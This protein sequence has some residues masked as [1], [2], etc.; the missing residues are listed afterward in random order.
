M[1]RWMLA[2]LVSV[3]CLSPVA[4]SLDRGKRPTVNRTISDRAISSLVAAASKDDFRITATTE[5]LLDGRPCRY[6]QVPDGV[7]IVLMEIAS[8]ESKEITRIHFRTTRKPSPSTVA[9]PEPRP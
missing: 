6:E 3:L 4:A 5:V 9:K 7:I 2:L 1:F 8:N